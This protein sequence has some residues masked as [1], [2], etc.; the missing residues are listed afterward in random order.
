MLL[1]RVVRLRARGPDGRGA[2][3]T[4]CLVGPGLV[5]TAAHLI[6]TEDGS[7]RSAVVGALPAT[8]RW[9]RYDDIVDAALLEVPGLAARPGLVAGP[10]RWG[11]LVTSRTGHPV[12]TYGYP[13]HQRHGSGRSEEQL[14]GR[15]NPGTGGS[16]YRW[17]LVSTDPLPTAYPGAGGDGS[18]WSG[19]SGAPVFSGDLL[20]GVVRG[21]RRAVAGSRLT[22]TRSSEL[23]RDDGFRA[24]LREVL[25]G[26]EPVAEPADLAG[27][28]EPAVPERDLRSPAMLL[29][30]DVQAAPFRGRREEWRQLS[31]WCLGPAKTGIPG[32][33]RPGGLSVRVLTGPGGQGKSRLARELVEDVARTPGWAAAL[34]RADLGDEAWQ[35]GAAPPEAGAGLA[36]LE[37]CARDLLLVV[38]Y[39]ESRPRWIRRLVERLRTPAAAG[40][41]VRL[42]LVARSTGGWQAD[43][44][45]ASPATHEILASALRSE[46]GPLDLSAE[47]RAAAFRSALDGLAALLGRATGPA[48]YDWAA[49]A[50]RVVPPAD[51]RGSRYATALNVQMEALVA[52]LQAGPEPL[53][54]VPG[55][56][57][58][59]TLLRHEERYWAR[60]FASSAGPG[61]RPLPMSLIRRMV[62]AAT[63]CGAADEEE[64]VA[65]LGRVPGLGGGAGRDEAWEYAEAIRRLYPA[66]HEAYWGA[67]Q[68]DRVA[69]FQASLLV[70]EVPGLLP[71]VAAQGTPAQQSQAVTVLTRAVVGHANS[72]RIRRRDGVLARLDALVDGPVLG[73]EVLRSAAASLPPSS[74]ALA[75]FTAR[76]TARLV[77]RCREEGDL[78]ADADAEGLAW[79]LERASEAARVLG[80]WRAALAASE[81]S[82]TIRRARPRTAGVEYERRL[83]AGL[84]QQAF[85]QRLA[86]RLRAALPV[87]EEAV[88]LCRSVARAEPDTARA[89]LADA[90]SVLARTYLELARAA[91]GV[92]AAEE[93]VE[94][95]R[96]LADE[97]PVYEARWATSLRILG[98]CQSEAGAREEGKRSAEAALAILRRLARENP[99]AHLDSL[100]STLNNLSW[101]HWR[102]GS[103]ESVGLHLMEEAVALRRRLAVGNPDTYND[104]LANALINLAASQQDEESLVTLDEAWDILWS[105]PYRLPGHDSDL[106]LLHANRSVTLWELSRWSEA[107]DE[108]TKAVDLGRR[109]YA[110]NPLVHGE[111]YAASL[112]RLARY[113]QDLFGR[114]YAAL[115]AVEEAVA[116]RRFLAEHHPDPGP[117]EPDR[118]FSCYL[119]AWYLWATGLP[120]KAAEAL[121]EGIALY[122]G[123]LAA[124]HD[125][126]RPD[127]AICLG[128]AATLKEEAG[129]VWDAL[130]ERTRAVDLL[131]PGPLETPAERRRLAEAFRELAGLG[132]RIGGLDLCLS[133]LPA[134]G[135]ATRLYAG[136]RAGGPLPRRDADVDAAATLWVRLLNRAGRR[137][138]ADQVRLRYGVHTP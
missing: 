90:L 59:A 2:V 34:L 14:A 128:L 122:E 73:T 45:D 127:L 68:P 100:A 129:R 31:D 77:E 41:T 76:L 107:I 39:A 119:R 116:V 13:R 64:A 74:D 124:G 87:A 49:V 123:R 12:E 121:A 79:A 88:E 86:G 98:G 25:D 130:D 118:A 80:D 33:S 105:L 133:V 18:G 10:P 44:Y 1:E 109:L 136:L 125:E 9:L 96:R 21:D 63:L 81:E 16:L 29:R 42:L 99:D 137:A 93:S 17:E 36:A 101:H 83:S 102:L 24:V 82:V 20:L 120:E 66:T 108:V 15:I 22:V 94:I 131:T 4:G 97:D 54:A 32:R 112:E 104:L 92:R 115:V 134:I 78:G 38:D 111:R 23:L 75:R 61:R 126:E 113:Q 95:R 114:S 72:G 43:P 11:D 85:A 53:D 47:D 117:Y 67:L 56:V 103:D 28:L 70:T 69:E 110:D 91:D 19:M 57:V 48:G 55:E 132:D 3:G 84:V 60:A 46:L 27:L 52:L 35:G 50:E 5:L 58:E 6:R 135:E 138:E 65:V 62:A 26:R 30:A 89:A 40:R 7:A 37:D 71:A 8:V 106:R 51:L